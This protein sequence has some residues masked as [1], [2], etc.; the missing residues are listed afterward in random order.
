MSSHA[1]PNLAMNP[2]QQRY[3]QLPRHPLVLCASLVGNPM[4]LGALCRTA[5]ACRLESLVLPDVGII[6][7]R[8][9]RR[10]AVTTHHWQPLQACAPAHLIPWLEAQRE[11]GYT[12]LALACD[13]QAQS[14]MTATFPQRA[15][16]L[17]GRELTGI[18]AELLAQCDQTLVIP[19]YGL[20]DSLNVQTAAAMAVY[21][22]LRQWGLDPFPRG[23][24]GD[25]ANASPQ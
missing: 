10:V 23:N 21:E 2:R 9:F 14:L 13:N 3:S 8:Q 6:E 16:L 25:P 15:V 18:P 17:L 7:E 20:V 4:N 1:V 5:E 12:R 11:R 22:Y 24:G 19:Q